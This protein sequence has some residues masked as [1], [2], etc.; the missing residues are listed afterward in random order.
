[1]PRD[2]SDFSHKDSATD[3][4]AGEG[5]LPSDD[6][7]LRTQGKEQGQLIGSALAFPVIAI[8][9]IAGAILWFALS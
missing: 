2:K 7:Y 6:G 8:L 1:M 5:G 9:V 4:S 3:R